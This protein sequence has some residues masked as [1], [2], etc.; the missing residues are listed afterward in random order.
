MCET[1]SARQKRERGGQHTPRQMATCAGREKMV[2]DCRRAY[3]E[4]IA[5]IDDLF[6]LAFILYRVIFRCMLVARTQIVLFMFLFPL[7]SLVLAAVEWLGKKDFVHK[8]VVRGA[9][10][11]I[12]GQKSNRSFFP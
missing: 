2:F 6:Y 7:R 11:R 3:V 5:Q 9:V 4:R 10:R 8:V 12:T 1:R